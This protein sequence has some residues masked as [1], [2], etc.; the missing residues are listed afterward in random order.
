MAKAAFTGFNELGPQRT[1]PIQPGILNPHGL[2]TIAI[3][4]WGEQGSANGT[5]SSGGLGNVT[6]IKYGDFRGGVP[7]TLV[8]APPVLP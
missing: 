8:P 7:V 1:F 3:A 6:L 2:N 5:D 4:V